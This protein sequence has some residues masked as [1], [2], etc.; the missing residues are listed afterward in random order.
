VSRL[1]QEPR[2]LARLVGGD[3]A[4]DTEEDPAHAGSVPEKAQ[5]PAAGGR[6]TA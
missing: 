1:H 6:A 4:G 3:P 2:Q 5:D